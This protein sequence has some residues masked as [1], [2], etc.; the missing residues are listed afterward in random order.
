[1]QAANTILS[2][3][4]IG[5]FRERDKLIDIVVRQPLDERSTITALNSV[6]IPTAAGRAVPLS[7]LA[8]PR[9]VW[10]PGV[11]W[12]EG[13]DWAITVQSDVVDGIQ[14]PTVSAQIDQIG[15]AHV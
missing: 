12:R 5:K 8:T 1:M 7:Q 10:E 3:T 4:T 13:R 6:S 15:R 14:G 9:F 2:G 11:V